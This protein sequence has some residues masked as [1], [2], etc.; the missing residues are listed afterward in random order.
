MAFN[1]FSQYFKLLDSMPLPTNDFYKGMIDILPEYSEL[2][3]NTF[4]EII[5][6]LNAPFYKHNDTKRTID[7]STRKQNIK[8]G[9]LCFVDI[10][11]TS[12]NTQTGQIIEIGA[13]IVQNEKILDR[14]DTLVYSPYVPDDI[15]QLTGIDSYM[16]EDAPKLQKVLHDFRNFIGDCV[17]VA[18]NV[19]FDY[20]FIS[21]SL[22]IYGMPPLLNARLCTLDLSRKSI[23]SKKHALPY[24]NTML[25]INTPVN[26]RALADAITSF[27]LYKICARSFPKEVTTI[28]DLI[29]FTK[30]KI[31]YPN[32]L[33]KK[34]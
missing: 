5:I 1:N 29:D 13:I 20:S 15:T 2:D 26:H 17:F 27:E 28:Q 19:G 12:A 7:L 23:I 33:I 10:E 31:K 22:K 34:N 14:F 8:D 16:L 30:N 4:F 3:F 18:H 21:E 11:S 9:K 32:R 25:G 6:G 24:L